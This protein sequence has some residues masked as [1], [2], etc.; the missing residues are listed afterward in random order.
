VRLALL[1]LLALVAA[2]RPA[3]KPPQPPA[4]TT[5]TDSIAALDSSTVIDTGAVY[6]T[7]AEARELL[8]QKTST[9]VLHSILASTLL[10]TGSVTI[11]TV[12]D[13]VVSNG[14]TIQRTAERKTVV[15]V[16]I[17]AVDTIAGSV[18]T[19]TT[20][21]YS[22]RPFGAFGLWEAQAIVSG[23]VPPLTAT[24][25]TP[26]PATTCGYITTSRTK[27]ARVNLFFGGGGH[28][29]YK[30]NGKFDLT[31]W[32][33]K[34]ATFG[35]AANKTC[36]AAGVADGTVIG[37][38]LLDE[39]EIADWGGVLTKPMINDMASFMKKMFPTLPVGP[40]HGMQG[41]NWRT[42]ERYTTVDYANYQ[43]NW[44]ATRPGG[45]LT[46]WRNAVFKQ[47]ALDGV[48]PA[49]SL[50]VINGG[51]LAGSNWN[52]TA[53]RGTRDPLCNMTPAQ[54]EAWGKAQVPGG[55]WL[56]LWTDGLYDQ[57][58]FASSAN[59]SALRAIA[60]V[61]AAAP[62]RSCRRP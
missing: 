26:A 47:A 29:Q 12:R 15:T 44:N 7:S 10:P 1:Y 36:V 31:K 54:L 56:L 11:D 52:C 13:T 16:T 43:F 14:Y 35:T 51:T 4:D 38:S 20:G 48:T 8:H 17:I 53:H 42:S 21:L 60:A 32:K 33:N 9:R 46:A 49:F 55:C 6:D 41:H 59:Q 2:C 58:F 18:E 61:T 30:T 25:I 22:G 34:M 40:N 24:I 28:A 45:D 5:A 37:G 19:P 23:R 3:P 27:H 50:N 39:P 62:A 57:P